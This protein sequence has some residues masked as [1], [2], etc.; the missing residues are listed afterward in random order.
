MMT[1]TKANKQTKKLR[2]KINVFNE[3]HNSNRKLAI[4]NARRSIGILE[5]P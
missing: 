4:S 5:I 2:K 3:I 1:L